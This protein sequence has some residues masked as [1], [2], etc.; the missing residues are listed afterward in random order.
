MSPLLLMEQGRWVA[1]MQRLIAA[2][3][4]CELAEARELALKR[5]LQ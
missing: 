4:K 3:R 2:R 1:R 5:A